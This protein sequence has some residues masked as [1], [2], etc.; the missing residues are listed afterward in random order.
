M[1]SSVRTCRRNRPRKSLAFYCPGCLKNKILNHVCH[2][3]ITSLPI[4]VKLAHILVGCMYI[5]LAFQHISDSPRMSFDYLFL[6]QVSSLLKKMCEEWM[7]ETPLPFRLQ[8]LEFPQQ[9]STPSPDHESS[10]FRMPLVFSLESLNL[11]PAIVGF[12]C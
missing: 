7:Q 3:L 5:T 10:F 8:R 9:M 1:Y 11:A 4:A 6:P 2:S 12:R